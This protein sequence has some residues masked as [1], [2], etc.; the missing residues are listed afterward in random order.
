MKKLLQN[1]E[2]IS[3]IKRQPREW[4]KIFA[5]CA[6]DKRLISILYKGLKI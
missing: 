5:H 2:T 3:K 4:E 6:T 1:K